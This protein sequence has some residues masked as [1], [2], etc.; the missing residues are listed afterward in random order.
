MIIMW[1]KLVV[2]LT[3]IMIL[4]ITTSMKVN[5]SLIASEDDLI[6]WN[7]SDGIELS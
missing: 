2:A 6:E 1:K 5:Q 7:S 3:I 4:S